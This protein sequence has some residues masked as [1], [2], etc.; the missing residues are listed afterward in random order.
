MATRPGGTPANRKARPMVDLT[1]SAAIEACEQMIAEEL[2]GRDG[3][4]T[5]AALAYW[6]DQQWFRRIR[7][8]KDEG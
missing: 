1:L 8:T 4:P 5:C 3:R 2:V 7:G 6:E